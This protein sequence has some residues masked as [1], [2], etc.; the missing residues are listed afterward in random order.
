VLT[1]LATD[2]VR[3]RMVNPRKVYPVD[4]GLIPLFDRSGKANLGHAL[5]TCVLHEL[6]RRAAEV[7]YVHT[8]DGHEI[9]FA[10]R[11]PDGRN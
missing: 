9:D 8:P 7:G 1:A 5:E 3:R 10:V 6:D 2:S 11:Y 4:M